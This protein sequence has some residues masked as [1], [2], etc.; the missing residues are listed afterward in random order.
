MFLVRLLLGA[1]EALE[2]AAIKEGH[3]GKV[4]ERGVRFLAEELLV[5]VE[6]VDVVGGLV[7]LESLVLGEEAMGNALAVLAHALVKR[8]E[9]EVGAEESGFDIRF[10]EERGGG[11]EVVVGELEENIGGLQLGEEGIFGIELG[12][13]ELGL[14]KVEKGLGLAA[15]EN[16]GTIAVIAEGGEQG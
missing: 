6:V 10:F 14:S 11:V 2:E 13:A 7:F 15:F 3:V 16:Q 12:A 9:E 1:V 4:G 8:G 5:A